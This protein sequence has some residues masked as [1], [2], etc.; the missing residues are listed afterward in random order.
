MIKDKPK[1]HG[2]LIAFMWLLIVMIF[3]MVII[4]GATRLTGSG[5]SMVDWHP[6][7]G[8]WPPMN[9]TEWLAEFSRYQKYPEFIKVYPDMILP[10]FKSIFWLEYIHRMWGRLLAI[11]LT[12][13]SLIIF[14]NHAYYDFRGKILLLWLL[15]G[16]QAVLGWYMVRSG[17]V[18][19]PTVSPYRLAAHLLMGVTIF[20]VAMSTT[21]QLQGKNMYEGYSTLHVDATLKK[22]RLGLILLLCTITMGAFVAGLHAGLIY[23]TFPTMDGKWIPDEIF[24]H[25]PFWVNFT[26]NP[27]TAQFVHRCLATITLLYLLWFSY[28]TYRLRIPGT[29]TKASI[30]LGALIV[31]QYALGVFTLLYQ[32]PVS[33]GTAHQGMAL[34]I[35]G[36]LV[37]TVNKARII[38]K[39]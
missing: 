13:P 31:C 17:L 16:G 25:K 23:N 6:L 39:T 15:G 29:I 37:Y 14:L 38:Q 22:G 8:I 24:F 28:S 20:W 4:G 10:E 3:M 7:T 27:A 30:V 36:T 5:L 9:E 34:L 33:L 32:V 1:S 12:I 18:N 2:M 26:E 19:D 35:F 11:V 21:I